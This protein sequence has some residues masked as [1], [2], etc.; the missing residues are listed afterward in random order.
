MEE[1]IEGKECER[2]E[3][4]VIITTPSPPS[5]TSQ[6]TKQGESHTWKSYNDNKTVQRT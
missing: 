1:R 3:G 2:K 5:I 4:K 6:E